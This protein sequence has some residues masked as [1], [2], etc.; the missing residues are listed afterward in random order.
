MTRAIRS[1][2]PALLL[3]AGCRAGLDDPLFPTGSQTVISSSDHAAVY[4]V[5]TDEGT[6][7]RYDTV[8]GAVTTLEVGREPSR[9]A[10]AKGK[11]YV[12][13]RAE[14]GIAVLEERD[15]ALV[16]TGR[17]DT[18]AE[19]V[20][21]VAREDGTRLYVALSTENAVV[22]LDPAT[23][24]VMRT[25]QVDGAP[26]WLALH[27]SGDTLY[28]GS[29]YGGGL[30]WIDLSHADS[31]PQSFTFPDLVGAGE[32]GDDT[33]T[34]R[35]TGDLAF[36]GDG[37]QLG[38][39]GLWV[40]NITPTTEP[41]S[42]E[43]Q[44]GGGYGSVGLGVSRMNPGIVLIDTDAHGQPRMDGARVMFV[45]G[46]TDD[47]ER[48]TLTVRSYLTSVAFSPKG[49]TIY[50]TMEASNTVVAMS[51]TPVYGEVSRCRDCNEVFDTGGGSTITAAA[52][53]F[54]ESPSVFIG[55]GAGPKGVAFVGDDEAFVHTWL[56][57]K[58]GA[59]SPSTAMTYIDEQ[60]ATGRTS[61]V[62]YSV[63]GATPIETSSLRADIEEGRLLFYSAI[64]SS[65]VSDGAGVSCST[66]HLD[67]RTDG[68][69]WN[70][71]V[72]R[73]Q[74]PSLAGRVSLTAPV[75]W[76]SEVA[77]VAREA[78]ITSQG[79][80]GGN[81]ITSAQLASIEAFVDS[82]RVPDVPL[83]GATSDAIERGRVIFNREDVGCAT[84]HSG[85]LY[86][87]NEAHDLYGLVGVNTPTLVGVAAT[88]P[89]LHDGSARNLRAVLD[90]GKTG[91]MGDT[92]MLSESDMD[93][94][95]AFV[96]SL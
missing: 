9:L 87:D 55:T 12:T 89:Y 37:D 31:V 64:D 57:R 19:P 76:T 63:E 69:T 17:L 81:G 2:L 16:M 96:S 8:T 46:F 42:G 25:F 73:R 26:A 90:T 70:I 50:G 77:S 51:T 68:L 61:T 79:R 67:A 5:N 80:M 7:S 41:D 33:L 72:G 95:E 22:E 84:C 82:T 54:V 13:L 56:D 94:L 40:D 4:A 93:D 10:R 43:I 11:V 27:P 91:L 85:A 78:E 30:S 49:D 71:D 47:A 18:G 1:V 75:T 44:M 39:P 3:L 35:I 83:A 38:V 53:G 6:V 74:T 60:Y 66:C 65:M 34:R 45:A 36:S 28:A 14:R 88:A 15:G 52:S 20:G 24:A 92:S 86:T 59:L 32:D 23:G 58:V 48:G 21:I 62:S 29:Q